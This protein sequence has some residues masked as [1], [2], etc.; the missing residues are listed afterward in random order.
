MVTCLGGADLRATD[1]GAADLL[2]TNLSLAD[3]FGADLRHN[4]W[5]YTTC[6][7]GSN[8]DSNHTHTCLEHL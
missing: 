4:V 8:S 7:D 2:G 5:K 6:P 3:L 1:L